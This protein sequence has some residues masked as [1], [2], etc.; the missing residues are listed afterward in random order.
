MTGS[1][2][3]ILATCL[4][5]SWTHH[6]SLEL[7]IFCGTHDLLIGTCQN[8]FLQGSLQCPYK[9]STKYSLSN[10]YVPFCTQIMYHDKKRSIGIV[11]SSKFKYK[12]LS[13][14]YD[15]H[16]SVN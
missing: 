2:G 11:G 9:N 3:G 5:E 15:D 8:F 16:Q 6:L 1:P 12:M 7:T 10:I 13:V 4:D 14:R